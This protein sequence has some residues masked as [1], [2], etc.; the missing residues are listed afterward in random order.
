MKRYWHELSDTTIRRLIT[1][2][3]TWGEIMGRYKQPD[4]CNYPDALEGIMGCWSLTGINTRKQISKAYCKKCD[5][6]A[7]EDNETKAHK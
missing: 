4:W 6:C 7:L 2:R 1:K 3:T 5:C